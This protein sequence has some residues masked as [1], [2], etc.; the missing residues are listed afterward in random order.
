MLVFWKNDSS[1]SVRQRMVLQVI[2]CLVGVGVSTPSVDIAPCCTTLP[3][4]L[5][6][7]SLLFTL[8]F[9]YQI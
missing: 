4:S 8:G 9:L 6:F 3:S 1:N 5:L 2:S 7:A